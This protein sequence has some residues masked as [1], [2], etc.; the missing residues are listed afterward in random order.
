MRAAQICRAV[1]GDF[2]DRG[3]VGQ[4]VAAL[5]RGGFGPERVDVISDDPEMARDVGGRSYVRAGVI[6]GALLGVAFAVV[7]LAMGGE[8]MQ[9]NPVG[10]VIGALGT[11]GGLAFIGL[12]FGRALVRRSDDAAVF[13]S[14]V[15]R[16]DALVCVCCEGDSC[17]KAESIL[18]QAGASEVRREA[19]TGPT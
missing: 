11:I 18:M 10:F 8:R 4:A 19:S 9:T 12:V 15:E 3:R 14:E 2:Q 6:S 5:A 16:G 7:V 13:A 17:E 1:V